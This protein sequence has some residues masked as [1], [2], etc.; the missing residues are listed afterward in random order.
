MKKFTLFLTLL[1]AVALA[2]RSPDMLDIGAPLPKGDVKMKDISGKEV[3]MNDAKG[4]NGL[5]VMFTCNT[6]PY[7][8][9][10]Q[11]RTQEICAYALKNNIGVILVNSNEA[12]RTAGDSYDAMKEYAGKQHYKWYY[13]LDKNSEVANAFAADRTPECYLFSKNNQ[14]VYKG[15]I[16]DHPGNPAEVKDQYLRLAIDGVLTG[17]TIANNNTA[18]V[19]CAIKRKM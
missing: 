2:F 11:A 4:T 14:L 15:A 19:G 18:S 16:D 6:C 17:K 1:A 13:V 9:R 3:S 12:Q 7:V 8:M 10:N 5:L